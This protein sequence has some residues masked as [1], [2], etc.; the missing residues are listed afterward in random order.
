[1]IALS[2]NQ[3]IHSSKFRL[4]HCRYRGSQQ[5]PFHCDH[6]SRI[7]IVL[8]GAVREVVGNQEV[9][10]TA[11][12]VVI[13][14]SDA[15]HLNEFHPNGARLLSIVWK[16]NAVPDFLNLP[17]LQSWKWQHQLDQSKAVTNFLQQVKQ[18]QIAADLEN[19][20]IEL[21][22]HLS[23]SKPRR[24]Q[25]PPQWLQRIAERLQ[26]EC[27]Q[28]LQVQDI[29]LEAGVHPV[30]LAR[31]FRKFYQCSIKEYLHQCRIRQTVHQLA[32]TDIAL[33]HLAF[34]AGFADQSHLNRQ[35]KKEMQLSPG[36]FRRLIKEV[37]L[38]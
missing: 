24:H 25:Q 2:D 4:Y 15:R 26:D 10:G 31:I 17:F 27:Q 37:D 38:K 13:K 11:T 18:A 7:S 21:V 3:S 29:A 1:M 30:Y 9:Y 5:F 6:N 12:S 28:V 36:Q 33:S 8:S 34:D 23:D 35:F 16:D 14:P 20:V 32:S 22:S 19:G